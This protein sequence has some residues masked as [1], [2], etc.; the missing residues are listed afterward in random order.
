MTRS[1]SMNSPP[2]SS[3]PPASKRRYRRLERPGL[4]ARQERVVNYA[5]TALVVLFASGWTYALTDARSRD[6]LGALV[7]AA[8]VNPLS[9]DAPPVGVFVI[10]AALRQF[11]KRAEYRGISGAVNVSVQKPGEALPLPDS[12]PP[13][14]RLEYAT[15]GDT[16]SGSER[17]ASAGVWN[18]I[19]RVGDAIRQ[20]PDL[21]VITLVPLSE[22]RAGRIGSYVIGSWPYES[23]GRPRSPAYAPPP[24]LVRV[25]PQNMNTQ[26]SE[27]FQLR[28]FL[29][30][31]QTNVWPKYVALSPQLL[32]KLELTVQ[33]LEKSGYDVKDVGVISGFR[34][35]S[36]NESGGETKGRGALSRH[37]Y[38][39]A[40]DI[41]IDSNGDGR[42]DDL[43]RDGRVDFNDAK[44]LG[45]AADRVEKAHPSLIG[46]IG[47][48]RSTG[49]HSGFVH[50]D[51][52]G[53]RA[54]W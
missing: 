23:G 12:L 38:G 31:G 35:P 28:D 19:V 49:A 45:A 53:F 29:T 21:S 33:E 32:D 6:S 13:N 30:K 20:V 4:T 44:V 16:A 36:Y 15:P 51:T 41:F 25:T 47:I 3:M 7:G 52:R 18:V 37:M 11:E 40:M 46:G 9:K 5:S 54:R 17:P 34:T 27:H 24:G 43:N 42:M 10:D 26:V 8:T 22:K 14:A 1:G 48:Y 50:I 39:D 2:D